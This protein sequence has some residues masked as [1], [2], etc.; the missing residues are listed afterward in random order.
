MSYPILSVSIRHEHDT[1]AARQRARQ[2]A[3]LLGFDGQDQTRIAT[4][5]SEIARNAF[6][7]A[8]GGKVEFSVEGKT[9]P[10]LFV[11]R[12][13]DHGPGIRNLD[14]ILNGQYVSPTGMG[15]G[16]S[17]TRRLLDQF[18]IDSQPGKGTVVTLTRLFP[19]RSPVI[20]PEALA[21]ITGQL[22]AEK[23]QDAYQELQ[24][25][26]QELL[27]A[28]DE[29][30]KRQE[31]LTSVN[32][33]LEDTNRGVVAL[34]AE[35]DEKADHLRRADELKSKFLSNMSH[36]FRSPLNSILAL[37][38][39]LLDRCDGE[40]NAEQEQ[41]V[42]FIR[43]AATDLL[44][45]VNDLLDL[46]KV[47]AGK[48]EVRPAEF[49]VDALFGTLRGMLRPLLANQFVNLVFDSPDEI[50]PL[51]TDEP[52]ISQILRNFISNA[53]KFT[54]KGEVRVAA[55][56]DAGRG[57]VTFSVA[58]TGIGIA[59]EDHE[60]IFQ[61]FVQVD[62]AL[63][64]R[65]KGTGL[66]LPLTRKLA[67]LLGG[68]V[69]V[70]SAPGLGS[71]F[72]A[73]IPMVYVA[74]GEP[75]AEAPPEIAAPP[76]G[77]VILVV[78]DQPETIHTYQR[79]LHGSEFSLV[80]ARTLRDARQVLDQIRPA[81]I[82][83]DVILRGED[84]WQFLADLKRGERT[85]TIP[86]VVISTVEDERKGY[87]LGADAYCVKPVSKA[88]LL[89]QL[90][91]LARAPDAATVLVIDDNEVDRYVLRQHLSGSGFFIL[92]AP[93]GQEGF[94][95]ARQQAPS[96]IVLDL[97]MPK[98][99]GYQT[100]AMLKK[101]PATAAIPVLICTSHIVG[102]TEMHRLAGLAAA[103]L[104]KESLTRDR[105]IEAVRN[106]ASSPA[107]SSPAGATCRTA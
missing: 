100:L 94:E 45:L 32:R 29:L 96:V 102:Q 87:H 8:Q 105:V 41:Q 58:D 78:E 67:T 107:Q 97:N 46:A 73:A 104:S 38:G 64:Q 74:P 92:E 98:V 99:D 101:D 82:V 10:Q 60:R 25:Q 44:E 34:Y 39:L 79:Y 90:R 13:S 57:L 19:R 48:V 70:E 43:H 69:W 16:I 47:E 80:A 66:G 22:A 61:D 15:L 56:C 95:L 37:S 59:P 30:R 12:V 2:L 28:L 1:V 76:T 75:A 93:G 51:F 23:P 52:K 81:A 54:E 5:V 55:Q 68:S 3:R 40:L 63:Q 18:H 14:R 35:L 27:A 42:T 20:A 26:N 21:R 72:Y 50:P 85:S 11:I 91:L 36:E 31:E 65:V 71:T 77:S 89:E 17:G 106:V 24:Q 88:R 33:E 103:V 9:A 83:L 84:S 7:Y 62:H 49:G 86:V 53:L 6:I 4:A